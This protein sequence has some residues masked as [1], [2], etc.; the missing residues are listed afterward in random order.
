MFTVH[1]VSGV[2]TLGRTP[3]KSQWSYTFRAGAVDHRGQVTFVPVTV[4]IIASNPSY[5]RLV[6]VANDDNV[7]KPMFPEC[8]AYDGIRVN[9]NVTAG[10]PVL[11]VRAIDQDSGP[12]GVIKYSL[13]NDFG[14][15]AIH[16][17]NQHGQITTTRRLDRDGD[18]KEFFLTVIARD[19]ALEPLQDTCT[20]R[21]VVEDVNDNSPI[22]DQQRYEQSLATDH[23][24][25]TP[26]LRVTASDLDSGSN[27][28][29]TYHLE[30]HRDHLQYFAVEPI[31]GVIT[32]KR[33]LDEAVTREKTVEM[34]VRAVDSGNPALWST[35]P[36]TIKLVSSGEL[37]PSVVKQEPLRPAILENTTENTEVAILCARSNLPDLT[38]VY[39]TLPNGKTRDSNSDGTFA[40]R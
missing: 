10:T 38:N 2:V 36:V 6:F 21:V 40:I 16:A 22:F 34:R 29:V 1:G 15:F 5:A 7:H 30:G 18:D 11:L 8:N 39:F 28:Q 20:F 23:S 4:H 27:G 33:T 32:L 19:G 3:G 17:S 35:A 24:P 13:I 9:E 37:P 12:E 14:S 25:A 26:I 31:T